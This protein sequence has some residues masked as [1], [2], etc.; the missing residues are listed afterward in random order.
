M[1]SW[2]AEY[3]ERAP[4][5]RLY[6]FRDHSRFRDLL[7][8]LPRNERIPL[9]ILAY[10]RYR[11]FDIL[12]DFDGAHYF[13]TSTYGIL[14]NRL[15]AAKLKP[16]DAEACVILGVACPHS[17]HGCNLL[18]PIELAER[19]FRNR[20]YPTDLFDSAHSYGETL[21]ALRSAQARKARNTLDLLLW[22]DVRRPA[23]G[24][25]TSR[26]QRAIAAMKPEE[27]FAWQWILR[28][29][30]A[31]MWKSGMGQAWSIEGK[32]RLAALG[33][34]RFVDRLDEWFSF[35]GEE[36]V[37]VSAAGSHILRL[38]VLYSGLANTMRTLPILARLSAVR[39]SQRGRMQKVIDGLTRMIQTRP[40]PP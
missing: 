37:R 40:L 16:T 1:S 22:H 27:A 23:R 7:K 19:A 31:G 33:E 3:S 29:P 38:L 13:W 14:I 32:L 6:F 39:W 25:W 9:L 12:N 11:D 35:A 34:N 15:L 17:G 20:P 26:I 5:D 28:N 4:A 10:E 30:S 8:K 18:Q 24:C 2:R 21:A 36:R